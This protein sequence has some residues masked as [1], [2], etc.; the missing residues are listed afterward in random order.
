MPLTG[1]ICRT[2]EEMAV[3]FRRCTTWTTDGLFRET[4]ETVTYRRNEGCDTVDMEC[5]ALAACA[6]FRNADL[7]MLFFTADSLADINNYDKRDF[8][9]ASLQPAL[10]LCL[11]IISS[12]RP[13][14]R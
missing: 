14:K 10:E 4:P 5:A 12:Y 2:L 6:K 9:T 11:R 13:E 1:H 8:G 3:H 7:G